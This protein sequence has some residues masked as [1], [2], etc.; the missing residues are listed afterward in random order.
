MKTSPI[1]SS[2][3]K[4]GPPIWRD[5]TKAKRQRA[6]QRRSPVP[7]SL[8]GQNH[9]PLDLEGWGRVYSPPEM[10]SQTSSRNLAWLAHRS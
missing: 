1:A 6:I 2:F 9:N 3:V 5:V 4:P 8:V 7:P 10:T